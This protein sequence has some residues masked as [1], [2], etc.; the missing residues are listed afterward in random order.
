MLGLRTKARDPDHRACTT[1]S[2][3][4]LKEPGKMLVWGPGAQGAE[5]ARHNTGPGK[6]AEMGCGTKLLWD[7]RGCKAKMVNNRHKRKWGDAV[8][9]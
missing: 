5:D 8:Y 9:E 6:R 4:H 1:P 3:L 2:S 7:A